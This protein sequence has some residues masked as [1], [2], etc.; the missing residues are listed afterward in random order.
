MVH[1][2][3]C[4]CR[5]VLLSTKQQNN[6]FNL[7]TEAVADHSKITKTLLKLIFNV[8]LRNLRNS[9]RCKATLLCSKVLYISAKLLLSTLE[10]IRMTSIV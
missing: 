3:I 10:S 5:S 7:N 8:C 9:N 1:V 6:N 2:C 4:A